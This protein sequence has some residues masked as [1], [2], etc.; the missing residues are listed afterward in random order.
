MNSTTKL[1]MA[2]PLTLGLVLLLLCSLLVLRGEG[3][4]R[5]SEKRWFL[6]HLPLPPLRAWLG[7]LMGLSEVNG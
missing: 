3:L 7:R 2:A 6:S 1:W 5:E 4:L